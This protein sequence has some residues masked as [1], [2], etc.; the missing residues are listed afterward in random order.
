MVAARRSQ[1]VSRCARSLQHRVGRERMRILGPLDM[2]EA[3]IVV[4]HVV[5][6]VPDPLGQSWPDHIDPD[7]RR[8]RSPGENVVSL[9]RASD[10]QAASAE[11]PELASLPAA[12]ST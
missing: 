4:E 6:A 7:L 2:S 12:E 8:I 11:V 10:F 9:T 3:D 1:T 5:A